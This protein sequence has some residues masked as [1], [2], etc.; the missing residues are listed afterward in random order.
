MAFIGW[1]T[2][3]FIELQALLRTN[4]AF[5]TSTE[6][7]YKDGILSIETLDG[8]THQLAL[9]PILSQVSSEAGSLDRANYS[10]GP[11]NT[12]LLRLVFC[13]DHETS[14][15]KLRE[16]FGPMPE[17]ARVTVEDGLPIVKELG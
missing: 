4:S 6:P 5:N 16:G 3:E 14:L 13:G 2:I 12:R 7:T 8:M 11:N 17:F 1:I 15:L 9:E 10:P